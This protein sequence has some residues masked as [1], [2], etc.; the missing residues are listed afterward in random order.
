MSLE[1]LLLP[2]FTDISTLDS[3]SSLIIKDNCR[4]IVLMWQV[5]GQHH[6]LHANGGD[7]GAAAQAGGHLLVRKGGEHAV[8]EEDNG[9]TGQKG[10][11]NGVPVHA[12]QIAHAHITGQRRTLGMG[13][14][15][16]CREDVLEQHQIQLIA[17][18]VDAVQG[19]Q[20][21]SSCQIDTAVAY[22]DEG[23]LA[24]MD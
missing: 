20:S 23:E 22:G 8:R 19:D 13:G 4:E 21:A 1:G 3:H 10:D 16:R 14:E 11:G 12:L 7:I 18:A 17:V 2:Y 15:R 9:I 5:F 6:P 24:V